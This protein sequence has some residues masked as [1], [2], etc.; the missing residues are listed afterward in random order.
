MNEIFMG[1]AEKKI[2]HDVLKHKDDFSDS[3]P[4]CVNNAILSGASQH[5]SPP[6]PGSALYQTLTY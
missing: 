5:F 4:L 2:T 6:C 1:P 3:L